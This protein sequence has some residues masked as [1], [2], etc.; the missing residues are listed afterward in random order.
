VQVA[1]Q[2]IS[3]REDFQS[4]TYACDDNLYRV[5][6]GEDLVVEYLGSELQGDQSTSGVHAYIDRSSGS[7]VNAFALPLIYQKNF[8][9]F[10]QASEP[11]HLAI[12]AGGQLHFHAEMFGS[13]RCD[14]V[15]QIGGYLQ[16]GP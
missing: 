5:P 12:P 3:I 7:P 1:N 6:A 14:A 10:W 13:S 11:V 2:E 8:G 9:I 4:S 16:P 15:I